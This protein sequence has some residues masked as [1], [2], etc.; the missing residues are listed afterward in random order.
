MTTTIRIEGMHCDGCVGRIKRVLEREP[1]IREAV[2][3]LDEERARVTH[4]DPPVDG[5]RILEL[6]E[7]AGFRARVEDDGS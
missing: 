2:V 6:V 4:A 3:S 1:G 5:A 7:G